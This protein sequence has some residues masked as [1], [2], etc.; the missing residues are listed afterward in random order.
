MK[1]QDKI[2][3]EQSNICLLYA[4]CAHLFHLIFVCVC[5]CIC[6]SF[7]LRLTR[8]LAHPFVR[9]FV[10]L[11]RFLFYSVIRN[12]F[13]FI[14]SIGSRMCVYLCELV[15]FSFYFCVCFTCAPSANTL[16]MSMDINEEKKTKKNTTQ[17]PSS[18]VE[19]FVSYGYVLRCTKRMSGYIRD[20]HRKM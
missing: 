7:N 18:L 12:G 13:R 8:L 17:S 9:S 1:G 16:Y 4:R 6:F 15:Q 10:R 11:F 19:F 2:I 20:Q 14:V 3:Y 5:E